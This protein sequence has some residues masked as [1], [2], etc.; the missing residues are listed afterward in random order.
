VPGLAKLGTVITFF[1]YFYMTNYPTPWS[2]VLLE[3]LTGSQTVEKFSAF[4]GT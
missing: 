4:N 3:K 2:T 1:L